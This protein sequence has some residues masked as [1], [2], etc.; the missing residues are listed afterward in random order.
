MLENYGYYYPDLDI[1]KAVEQVE[2]VFNTHNTK[3]YIEKHK[4]LLH[5][6]SIHNTY[7]HEW[8]KHR[9]KSA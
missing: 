6:Y 1:N 2:I 3:L 4:E 8:V 5:K 9:L 7:Y